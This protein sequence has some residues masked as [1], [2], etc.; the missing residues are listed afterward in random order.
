M[1]KLLQ[2]ST[3]TFLLVAGA[4]LLMSPVALAGDVTGS[5]NYDGDRPKA[6]R[7][8]LIG[9]QVCKDLHTHDGEL[10]SP[11]REGLIVTK[12]LKIQN[13]FVY[14][15]EVEGKF[16]PPEEAAV[17]SQEGCTYVPHVLGLVKG[18]VLTILNNDPTMHNVHSHSK[19]NRGFNRGHLENAPPIEVTMRRIESA[20]KISCDVHPWMTAFV[21]VLDHPFFAV[22]DENGAFTI[23]D[24]P[25][26]EYTLVASHERL[27]TREQVITVEGE[28]FSD[29][30]FT[31]GEGRRKTAAVG[32]SKARRLR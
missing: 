18:Q 17:L 2:K 6:R 23:K 12:D 16:N 24:L 20:I 14:I 1:K 22:T 31:F 5:V 29:A 19:R 32:S 9:D 27:G 25:P 11:R 8:R 28:G 4:L 7:V 15:K 3:M 10:R 13:V 21:H 26:G 30:E